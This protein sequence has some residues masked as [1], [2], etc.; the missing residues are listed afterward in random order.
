MTGGGGDGEGGD[1]GGDDEDDDCRIHT[2]AVSLHSTWANSH[3]LSN[4]DEAKQSA[5]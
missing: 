5:V 3:N 2:M 4:D 1:G